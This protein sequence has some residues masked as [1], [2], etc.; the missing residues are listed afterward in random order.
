MQVVQLKLKMPSCCTSGAIGAKE[1][2]SKLI[3]IL[4]MIVKRM[5]MK[6]NKEN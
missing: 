5:P 1:I 6:M 2:G 3:L 4:K